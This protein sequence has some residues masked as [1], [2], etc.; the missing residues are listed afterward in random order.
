MLFNY[1]SQHLGDDERLTRLRNELAGVNGKIDGLRLRSRRL[2]EAIEESELPIPLLAKRLGECQRE[3]PDLEKQA[4]SLKVQLESLSS[5]RDDYSDSQRVLDA[6]RDE[7]EESERIRA[8]A[9]AK[10]LMALETLWVWP[11]EMVAVQL[12]GSPDAITLPLPD[13]DAELIEQELEDEEDEEDENGKKKKVKVNT[14]P[15]SSRVLRA[16][17][18]GF[19]VPTPR[20]GSKPKIA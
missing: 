19:A 4:Q 14:F 20:R 13:P 6:L 15:L 10:M 5:I 9:H 12:K 1:F 3:L 7:S 2:A 16:Y 18:P 11:R 17:D 8:E